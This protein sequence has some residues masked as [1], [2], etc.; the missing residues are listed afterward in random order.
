MIGHGDTV[1]TQ[2]CSSSEG[3]P[4]WTGSDTPTWPRPWSDSPRPLT[5][6]VDPT[7]HQQ[8]SGHELHGPPSPAINSRPPDPAQQVGRKRDTLCW[9]RKLMRRLGITE[10]GTSAPLRFSGTETCSMF[11]FDRSRK[12]RSDHTCE[13]IFGSPIT[14]FSNGREVCATHTASDSARQINGI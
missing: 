6:P 13:R 14:Q 5:L 9:S 3:R 2:E 4:R 8:V 11:I 7:G 1:R 12:I 10:T